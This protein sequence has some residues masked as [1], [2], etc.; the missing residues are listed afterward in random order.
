MSI[1]FD[2]RKNAEQSKRGRVATAEAEPAVQP[3]RPSAAAQDAAA[4]D[5]KPRRAPRARRQPPGTERMARSDAS[6]TAETGAVKKAAKQQTPVVRCLLRT[7]RFGPLAATS[8]KANSG[9]TGALIEPATLVLRTDPVYPPI[10][11]EQSISGRVEVRFRINPEGKVYD[12][13]P[14][15][16]SPVLA[17]AAVE[18]VQT[19]CYQ[20]AR[21]NGAAIDWQ[22]STNI[23]FDLE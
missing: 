16:G 17:E 14:V 19:W 21:L 18:A 20:P 10:A 13:T 3:G 15:N 9:R 2:A 7:P 11:K 22:A 8:Q 4:G 12:V 6:W 5:E 23:D 1:V